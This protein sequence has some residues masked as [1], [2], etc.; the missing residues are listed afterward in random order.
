MNSQNIR[1]KVKRLDNSY[2]VVKNFFALSFIFLAALILSAIDK[3]SETAKIF[4]MIFF[5]FVI[6]LSVALIIEF[7]IKTVRLQNEPQVKRYSA[8][9]SL[10]SIFGLI[11]PMFYINLL[12][13]KVMLYASWLENRGTFFC[14]IRCS[15]VD[16]YYDYGIY[17]QMHKII[18]YTALISIT[19]FLWGGLFEKRGR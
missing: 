15:I 19:L 2:L 8:L 6:L 12:L 5:G 4:L 9:V 10:N 11:L 17:W 18:F 3:R 14:K 7:I 1:T 13:S 16:F